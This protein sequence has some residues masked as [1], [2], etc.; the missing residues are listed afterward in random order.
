[1]TFNQILHVYVRITFQDE[2]SS[3]DEIPERD[4]TYYLTYDYLFTTENRTTHSHPVLSNAYL[5]HIMC[6]GLLKA[7][8]VLLYRLSVFLV[9]SLLIHKICALCGI[10]SAI[11][12]Y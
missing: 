6:V 5:L 3:G 2:S 1:M 10:F 11:S 7:P 8:Y 12:S 4:V 9:Y